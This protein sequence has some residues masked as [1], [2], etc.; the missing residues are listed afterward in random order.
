M[1]IRGTNKDKGLTQEEI[2]KLAIRE[3][4]KAIICNNYKDL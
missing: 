3:S 1:G 2:Y 4:A